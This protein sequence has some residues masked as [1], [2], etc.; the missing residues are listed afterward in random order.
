MYG[1]VTNA[2]R[3]VMVCYGWWFVSLAIGR[4]RFED[5]QTNTPAYCL[6]RGAVRFVQ[7]TLSIAPTGPR[8][9]GITAHQMCVSMGAENSLVG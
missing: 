8:S 3:N 1:V 2:N 7:H 9:Q 5:G 6:S 4:R